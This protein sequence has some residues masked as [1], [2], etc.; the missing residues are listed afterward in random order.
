MAEGH[1][2]LDGRPYLLK[3]PQAYR[4]YPAN[5]MAPKVGQGQSQYRDLT[6]WEAWIVEN[7]QAGIGQKAEEE[8]MAYAEVDSRVPN[9][10]VLPPLLRLSDG[11]DLVDSVADLRYMP[12]SAGAVLTVGTTD[13]QRVSI[14]IAPAANYSLTSLWFYLSTRSGVTVELFAVDA[15]NLP[16]GAAIDSGVIV[17]VSEDYAYRWYKAAITESLVSGTKYAIVLR[18]S[19]AGDSFEIASGAT[20]TGAVTGLYDGAAWAATAAYFPLF[21]TD[22]HVLNA[23][24]N[25][26]DVVRFNGQTYAAIGDFIYKYSSGNANWTAVGPTRGTTITD[27]EVVGANLYIGLGNS[28]N[29]HTM[30]TAEAYTSAGSAGRI[31]Y[32]SGRY[33]WKAIFGSVYYSANGTTWSSAIPCGNAAFSVRGLAEVDREMYAAT[34]DG[35]FLIAP[36]DVAEGI[37]PW[38]GADSGSGVDMLAHQGVLYTP[39]AG[40]YVQ[41]NGGSVRNIWTVRKTEL[42]GWASGKIVSTCAMLNWPIVLVQPDSASGFATVWAWQD[43]GWHFLAMLPQ[44]IGGKSVRYDR[45]NQRLW[46]GTDKGLVFSVYVSNYLINPVEDS[47]YEYMPW[48][49]FET[50][51]F[52]GGILES[53][54]D[55]ESLY[56]R[57][58][59][60]T[61]NQTVDAYWQDDSTGEIV[62]LVDENGDNIGDENGDVIGDETDEWNFFGTYTTERDEQRWTLGGV[63]PSTREIRLGFRFKTTSVTSTPKLEAHRL[64]YHIMVHDWY[65]WDLP[66]AISGVTY[67]P[68]QMLDG[69]VQSYTAFGQIEHLNSLVVGRVPPLLFRDLDGVEYEVKVRTASFSPEKVERVGGA[70]RYDGTYTLQIEATHG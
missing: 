18:P 66:L 5:Q 22:V 39:V 46:I 65:G 68:Q 9:Q 55:I 1:I 15:N 6:S 33:L 13:V 60:L 21:F 43:L 42:P 23:G 14:L 8:G 27:L 4:R 57:G 20:Y 69:G 64:K 63:R 7:W 36:G 41:I 37:T 26:T 49:W 25:V 48:G 2:V 51:W 32:N 70:L 28:S 31:F 35:L 3:N 52:S 17:P 38:G 53:D 16:T 61:D 47:G 58:R 45:A 30:S 59:G 56:L 34:D 24:A 29:Y 62:Y 10:L 44:G 54:K 40:Q 11:R 12:S 67:T 19:N 50:D